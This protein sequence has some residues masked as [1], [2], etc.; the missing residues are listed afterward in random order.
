M[1]ITSNHST[2]TVVKILESINDNNYLETVHI[3]LRFTDNDLH[4][5]EM[6]ELLKDNY[7][8]MSIKSRGQKKFVN[9]KLKILSPEIEPFVM[10]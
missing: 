10:I 1:D 9:Q 4:Q 7:A 3:S 2:S 5:N 6:I 8:I